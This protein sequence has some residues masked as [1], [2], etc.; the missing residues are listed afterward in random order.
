LEI[1]GGPD[2]VGIYDRDRKSCLGTSFYVGAQ[3]AVPVRTMGI[4]G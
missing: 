3:Y 4:V 2:K 1:P